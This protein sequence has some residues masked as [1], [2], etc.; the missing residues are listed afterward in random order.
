MGRLEL[1]ATL[2]GHTGVVWG[3]AWSPRGLLAT[4]GADRSVRVWHRTESGE[5]AA[6]AMLGESSFL[7]AVRSVA[8]GSD[9]RSLAC[10]CFDASATVLE[11]VGGEEPRLEAAVALEGHES[12]VK[13]VAYSSSGGLLATCSRDKSVW[14]WEVGMD[15][16]YECIA[17]L[18]GHAADVKHVNWHPKI[19]MLVSCSY[20]NSV[21]VW[22]EDEDDWFCAETLA[23][24]DSTVWATAFDASGRH[25]ATVS[26]DCSVVVW[27]REDPPA[28]VIGAHP[29]FRVIARAAQV[30]DAPIYSVSWCSKFDVIATGGGDDAIHVLQRASGPVDAETASEVDDA[31]DTPKPAKMREHWEVTASVPRAH[32]GDVN[33]VTWSPVDAGV[34]AS[35]GDDGIVRI[36]QYYAD[37][38]DMNARDEGGQRDSQ[39]APGLP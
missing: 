20:D 32:S 23:A 22:V 9:G 3:V 25:L 21:R 5:W 24:H 13:G 2:R 29:T 8:W 39:G 14:V 31:G 7:R 11:L 36:W 6:V 26:S 19:E 38:T 27:R 28:N 33:H 37:S 4:C 34:L 17:V 1:Q 16:D 18:N 10:A 12:E 30:H 15:F 35:C